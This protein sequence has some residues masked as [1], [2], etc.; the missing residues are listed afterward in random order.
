L[1]SVI[2]QWIVPAGMF[3]LML[4]MGLTLTLDDFRRIVSIPRPTVVGTL[5]QLVAMPLA[6]LALAI[7]FDLEPILAAGLVVIAACPGGAM[8]NVL[9]H[10]GKAD[11]AL[12]ITLTATATMITLFTIPL[13]VR[14]AS[15]GETGSVVDM[16]FVD[17]ALGLGAFTVL[18]V[19]V[20]MA[21]RPLWPALAAQERWL[22]RVSTLVIV[23]ALT[24]EAMTNEDPPLAALESTWRPALL[25][26]VSALVMG[27]GLPLLLNLG[28]RD[29][30]TI[31]VEISIKNSVLGLFVTTE[32]LRSLE[33]AAPVAVFMT[34]QVPVGIGVLALYN[35]WRRRQPSPLPDA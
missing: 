9:C 3:V 14:I 15:A 22:T 5:L 12:S 25:L 26:L 13:W 32:A 27:I 33:A 7:A 24:I 16:P 17:T 2:T 21:L 20:G 8:S 4:A 23:V 10:L 34:F 28:A 35:L 18:P 11:T 1:D 31:A 19:A 30:A 29:A 6:G